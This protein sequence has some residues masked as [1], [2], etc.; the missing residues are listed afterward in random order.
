VTRLLFGCVFQDRFFIGALLLALPVWLLIY[1]TSILPLPGRDFTPQQLLLLG[2][3]FPLLE[4]L[5][6][7]GLVQGFLLRF[8]HLAMRHIGVT[9]ANGVTSLLF[10]AAHLFHQP[11][12]IAALTLFPSLIFGEL[13][14]RFGSTRPSMFMHVYYNMGLF[15]VPV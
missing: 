10:A 8:P 11:P 15:L 12:V 9:S 2:L 5:A 6:F 3:I 14:D 13:R 1:F 4:E 7:R